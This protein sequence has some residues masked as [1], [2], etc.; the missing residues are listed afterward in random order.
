MF[1][2]RVTIELPP[3]AVECVG[4][5]KTITETGLARYGSVIDGIAAKHIERSEMIGGFIL[6]VDKVIRFVTR[7]KGW[8]CDGCAGCYY[9]VTDHRG[10]VH[11][12]VK[13]EDPPTRRDPIDVGKHSNKGFN[14]RYT[15]ANKGRL[16]K[17]MRGSR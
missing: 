16:K 5:T 12:V 2:A 17:S 15:Q 11:P 3:G 6:P 9:S 14:T 7:R 13:I 10:D 4:C 8:L 1:K